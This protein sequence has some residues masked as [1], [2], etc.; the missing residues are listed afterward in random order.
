MTRYPGRVLPAPTP[1]VAIE[2]W[3]IADR[4]ELDGLVFTPGDRLVEYFSPI[5]WFN[6]FTVFAPGGDPR[7]WYANVTHL[8]RL[9][10]TAIPPSL[11]WH[12]LYLDLV[13][14][15]DGTATIRDED[16]L[17]AANLAQTA[18]TLYRTIIDAK[19]ELVR[20]FQARSYPFH[21]GTAA[22]APD[23]R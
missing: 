19:S 10:G 22:T 20:R 5:E 23:D 15:P 17:A 4:I 21:D 1:W 11:T 16:E 13:A 7:G 8:P 6:V 12:D 18:P 2:A 14:L 9:D 3:W